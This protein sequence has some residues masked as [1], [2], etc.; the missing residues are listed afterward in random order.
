[1]T[2]K[3]VAFLII[4]IS[5]ASNKS[6]AQNNFDLIGNRKSVTLSFKLVNNLMLIP[7]DLNGERLTFIVDTGVDKSLLFNVKSKDSTKLRQVKRVKIRG[8]GGEDYI[9]A[10]ISKNNLL[11][12]NNIVCPD[13]TI[14]VI[15]NREFDFSARLGVEVNGIIGSDLFSD[16]IVEVNYNRKKIKLS[17]PETYQYKKC[18]KCEDFPLTFHVGKPYL[19]GEIKL[20]N[21]IIPVKL[22][23]DSGSG[24]SIWMFENSSKNITVPSKNFDDF[25]G[26]GLSGNIFGKK[27][28]L[29]KLKIGSFVFND[30]ISAFPDST[31]IF[32]KNLLYGRNGMIGSEILK[33][34]HIIYDYPNKKIRLKKNGAFY[35]KPFVYNKSGIEVMHNGQMLVQESSKAV[36]FNKGEDSTPIISYSYSLS[37]RNSYMISFV[38]SDSP[39]ASVG[40]EIDDIILSLNGK[41]TYEFTLQELVEK[42][43]RNSNKKIKLLIDRNGVQHTFKFKLVD[44]L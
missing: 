22:L 43:S 37:F 39:A 5:I 24:E 13:Y 38:K 11:R 29:D 23:I 42:L 8:L 34:F 26:K 1:M 6:S 12:I 44:L 17:K 40:L 2:K 4:F 25:L 15:L 20:N 7:I 31:A 35:K 10:L 33:R 28:K 9:D 21:K 14:Y 32:N 19:N 27:A 41:P 18:R 36:T 30:V 16:F 3:I